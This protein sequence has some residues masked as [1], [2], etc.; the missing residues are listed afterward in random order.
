MRLK[1]MADLPPSFELE[2]IAPYYEALA[3][4]QGQLLLK[5]LLDLF[6]GVLLLVLL[7]P[8]FL[9]TAI[10]IKLDSKGPVFYL[11]ERVT[12]YGRHFHIVKFRTMVSNADRIGA[13][14]TKSDDVRITRVGRILRKVH[15]DEMSQLINVIKGDMT[16]VGTRPE[17]P[18]FVAAYT[19]EM[20]ATLLLPAGVT[21]RCSVVYRDENEIL[22]GVENP[23]EVYLEKIL[24]DKMEINLEEIRSFH[25]TR[26]LRTLWDTLMVVFQ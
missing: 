2:A 19:P 7:S 6:A 13:A 12:Q 10:A 24:P 15:L 8:F 18:K 22:E 26:D 5:R 1:P 3:A 11:Q 14:V 20:W 17:V 23:E 16:F 21:S 4:H 9:V 25:L